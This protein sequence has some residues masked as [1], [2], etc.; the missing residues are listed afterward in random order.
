LRKLVAIVETVEELPLFIEIDLDSGNRST[1][2]PGPIESAAANDGL[3]EMVVQR[4]DAEPLDRG[5][6]SGHAIEFLPPHPAQSS[7]G[8][9]GQQNAR[10]IANPDAGA[11]KGLLQE[12]FRQALELHGLRPNLD[13]RGV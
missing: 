8:G 5:E 1:P 10:R 13:V 2:G 4:E 3:V 11:A 12:S 9:G 6:R 7:E